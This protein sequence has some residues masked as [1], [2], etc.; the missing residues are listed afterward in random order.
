MKK[1]NDYMS[2]PIYITIIVFIILQ[3]ALPFVFDSIL[4]NILLS[5]LLGIIS[6][7]GFELYKK[8][9]E[10]ALFGIIFGTFWGFISFGAHY[11]IPDTKS[12]SLLLSFFVPF[13]FMFIY[14]CS[15]QFISNVFNPRIFF[16]QQKRQQKNES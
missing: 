6:L 4:Y 9:S 13:I 15:L 16:E 10:Y 5:F 14:S 7:L 3:F 12:S 1:S 11:A 2:Y 8:E